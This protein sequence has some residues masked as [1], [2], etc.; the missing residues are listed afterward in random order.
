MITLIRAFK[1]APP[2]H[3]WSG[4]HHLPPLRRLPSCPQP[5]SLPC[6]LFSCAKP[7]VSLVFLFSCAKPG[8]L[9][10][11][12]WNTLLQLVHTYHLYQSHLYFERETQFSL[13]LCRCCT[14]TCS[15]WAL[16]CPWW[17][18]CSPPCCSTGTP[19]SIWRRSTEIA[20]PESPP[21]LRKKNSI[22]GWTHEIDTYI[23]SPLVSVSNHHFD[24]GDENHPTS[25]WRPFWDLLGFIIC[26]FGTL[27][28]WAMQRWSLI[29]DSFQN[30]KCFP[31]N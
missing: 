19:S 25:C 12:P 31:A 24:I 21:H 6:S 10:C 2:F 5:G 14:H 29:I 15:T 16:V 27:A 1:A 26:A 28:V 18:F 9:K 13:K 30:F 17:P 11:S 4:R 22:I 7:V 20:S 8:V 23:Y 3:Q